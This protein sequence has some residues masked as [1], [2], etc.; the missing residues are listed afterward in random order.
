MKSL[1]SKAGHAQLTFKLYLFVDLGPYGGGEPKVGE[2][3][4]LST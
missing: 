3:T 2:V 1:S 4:R